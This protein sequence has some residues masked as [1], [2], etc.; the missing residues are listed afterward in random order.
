MLSKHDSI[1]RDQLEMITLDQLVPPNHLV[2]KLEAAID[3]TFI[4]DL[5]KDMYSEVG[6]PSIDPVILVKLTF[7]QYTFGI[8]S[9]RKTIEEVET[10]MAYRW[11]LGYGFHD[12][13]PH[14]S[15]FGKNYERRFK[16]TDLFEQI[17]YRI[18]MTAANK[19]LISAEHVFVDST[20][21]KASANKRKFEKKIVR[22]E[23]RAY[24]GRLQEEINQDREN[25]G[26]K[27]FPSDKFD[28]EE[29]K[30]IKESTTDSESGYYV[31]D[32]RTKQFAYSFHAAADRNGFVLGTIVTPG[33]IHDSQ[34]LEPLVEQ[35][36]EKI[37]KPEAVA[38][39]AAYKTPAITSYLFNKEII[40]ALP[41][42]RPR[43]KEGFFRKQDYV[44]DE[45]FDCYLCPSGE[46]LKYSTTNK[47]GYREYKSPKHTCAT[48]SFLSQCTESKDH[49]K[50][51]TRHIWQTH[52]EEADHLRHHQ[53]VKTIYAKRKETIER[54]FAD[55]KEKHGMRWTTLRGLKKL[56]MQA[57]LTFA[58]INLKKMANWTWG[59]PKMA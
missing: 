17:F 35:V 31:K 7:I 5:V 55:A 51:V 4:Y 21:V 25:H 24:Q 59:G 11:F 6:R 48:C 3:F 44:Y 30:E 28:K 37:G 18:L 29:T 52:V 19:K 16:D 2:R 53:D 27:P 41:Y 13:V 1:Q 26:K 42:T 46:L 54:V 38:A 33:N 10:N 32:E 36:I 20:H 49:Q 22:K 58:A 57:M 15:T 12:K 39:D 40:P 50:V 47:E 9:M 56:S 34:I 8:R 23:T 43:T 45:H 14:F